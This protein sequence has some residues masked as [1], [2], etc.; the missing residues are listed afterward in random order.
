MLLDLDDQIDVS[1]FVI[2]GNLYVLILVDRVEILGLIEP[3]DGNVERARIIN[4][5]LVYQELATQNA[6]ARKRIA[7]EFEP[8]QGELFP[9]IDNDFNI[10]NAFV[11]IRT[12]LKLRIVFG[13]IINKTLLPVN[14][15]QILIDGVLKAFAICDLAGFQA[16]IR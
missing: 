12:V 1:M 15:F 8:P 13:I 11:R 2:R 9:F 16:D 4:I 14:I 10:Y 3:Q 5:S 6:I 7:G